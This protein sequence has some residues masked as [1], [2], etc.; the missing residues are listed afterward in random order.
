MTIIALKAQI[1]WGYWVLSTYPINH[2]TFTNQYTR[3]YFPPYAIAGVSPKGKYIEAKLAHRV[4]RTAAY[5]DSMG[6]GICQGTCSCNFDRHWTRQDQDRISS[7]RET[8]Q[9]ANCTFRRLLFRTL[10]ENCQT[11]LSF[12]FRTITLT[13]TPCPTGLLSRAT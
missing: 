2:V 5:A 8:F 1:L 3:G 9:N 13:R 7:M 12:L 11:C 6:K 4:H 10:A